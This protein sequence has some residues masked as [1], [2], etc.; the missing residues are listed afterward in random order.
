M[1]AWERWRFFLLFLELV[2]VG[3]VVMGFWLFIL[4]G[5]FRFSI[6]A[7]MGS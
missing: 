1:S 6:I 5:N 2:G 7:K 3:V 4:L